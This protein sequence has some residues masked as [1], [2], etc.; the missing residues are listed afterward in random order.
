MELLPA[1]SGSFDDRPD[2]IR[3]VDQTADQAH[4]QV[5]S[6]EALRG[7]ATAIEYTLIASIV[8][9][10]VFAGLSLIGQ[11]LTGFFQSVAAGFHH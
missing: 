6:W 1:L 8:S 9:I 4:D 2:A 5:M 3:F 7:A 11:S 10:C